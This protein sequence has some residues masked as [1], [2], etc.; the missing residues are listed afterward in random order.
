MI[1]IVKPDVTL[2]IHS[3]GTPE[4]MTIFRHEEVYVEQT[5]I[6]ELL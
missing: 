5:C 4:F 6:E 1:R 3:D 2:I